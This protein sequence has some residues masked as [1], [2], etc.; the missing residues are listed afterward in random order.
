MYISSFADDTVLVFRGKIEMLV[1]YGMIVIQFGKIGLKLNMSKTTIM[2]ISKGVLYFKKYF[3][4][5]QQSHV[6][7]KY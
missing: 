3:G 4:W 6:N 7:F 2:N 1:V 5:K